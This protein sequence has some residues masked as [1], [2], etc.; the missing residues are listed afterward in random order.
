MQVL[1]S[2]CKSCQSHAY[3]E[4][5]HG[6]MVFIDSKCIPTIKT[7]SITMDF[8]SLP[9]MSTYFPMTI[10][11]IKTSKELM[12]C[13][14]SNISLNKGGV[15]QNHLHHLQRTSANEV[16]P[17]TVITQ[18][19]CLAQTLAQLTHLRIDSQSVFCND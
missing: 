7:N 16:A 17:A 5:D 14:A 4:H 3:S 11:S 1:S 15:N 12:N 10:I 13:T 18:A 6:V 8:L 2:S 19:A 9:L